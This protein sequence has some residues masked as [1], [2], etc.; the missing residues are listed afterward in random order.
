[1]KPGTLVKYKRETPIQT[2]TSE[3]SESLKGYICDITTCE[4]DKHI[5]YLI[6]DTKDTY[7]YTELV[8]DFGKAPWI[9]CFS[10]MKKKYFLFRLHEL[11][12]VEL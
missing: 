8:V 6:T 1:M 2:E 4:H 9:I 7:L 12:E 11:V 5:E 3:R 10:L